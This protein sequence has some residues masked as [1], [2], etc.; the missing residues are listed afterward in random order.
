MQCLECGGA[1]ANLDNS[2]LLRCCSLTLQ[3]YAI[4]HHLPLDILIDRELLNRTDNPQDYPRPK[5]YPSEQARAIYRGLKWGGLLQREEAFT[6]VP[7]EIRRL[8]MLL[9][10]LQWL[11]EYGFLFRQEYRYAEETHR[12]VAVNRLKVPA[13]YLALSAEAHLSPVPPPRF[14]IEP[15]RACRP[16]RR[17]AGWI[18]VSATPGAGGRGDDNGG[19]LPPRYRIQGA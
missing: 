13:A 15:G 6:I 5:A 9:W 14:F 16:Y 1:V 10:N 19:G 4:R 8:D 17:A 2:H 3:E 18:P 7:G 11:S 12:V